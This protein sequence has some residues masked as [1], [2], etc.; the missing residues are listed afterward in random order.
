MNYMKRK[1]P[2]IES[3]ALDIVEESKVK[4]PLKFSQ[5]ELKKL[6]IELIGYP[7][8]AFGNALICPE[9]GV[10]QGILTNIAPDGEVNFYLNFRCDD[11]KKMEQEKE[12]ALAAANPQPTDQ[13]VETP[14][15]P[16][17]PDQQQ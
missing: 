2:I 6:T 10:Q 3:L 11:Y 9:C 13:P 16:T 4:E 14:V 12:A 1:S 5:D 8:I 15:E 7:F 17:T